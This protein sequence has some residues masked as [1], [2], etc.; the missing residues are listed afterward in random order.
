[1]RRWWA[2]LLGLLA[3]PLFLGCAT[4]GKVGPRSW[5]ARLKP[6]CGPV[7]PDAVQ[8]DVY[9]VTGPLGDRYLN[10]GVWQVDEQAIS[11]ETKSALDDNGFRVGQGG[12]I[13]PAELVA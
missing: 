10:D 6:F 9:V 1:M 12:G 8:M 3:G 4:E 2:L 13:A 7:G 11:L 5:L